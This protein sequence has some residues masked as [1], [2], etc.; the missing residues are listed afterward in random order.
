MDT[1]SPKKEI[2]QI[3]TQ[4]KY[5]KKQISRKVKAGK[6]WGTRRLSDLGQEAMRLCFPEE[7]CDLNWDLTGEQVLGHDK[8]QRWRCSSGSR[9]GLNREEGRRSR[10]RRGTAWPAQEMRP[11]WVEV[12]L[13]DDTALHLYINGLSWDCRK[14]SSH[15]LA[16]VVVMLW[17]A[18]LG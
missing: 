5:K 10:W 11:R 4:W 14:Q 6:A 16:S 18:H 7:K 9:C 3:M 2:T 15:R 1:L 13:S 17:K 8:R 12:R